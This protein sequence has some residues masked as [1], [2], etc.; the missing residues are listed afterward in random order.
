MYDVIIMVSFAVIAV[1]LVVK[2]V[3]YCIE[4]IAQ[5]KAV[6]KSLKLAKKIFNKYEPML[7]QLSENMEDLL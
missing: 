7:D 6:K 5:V 4:V 1:A 2:T 3:F